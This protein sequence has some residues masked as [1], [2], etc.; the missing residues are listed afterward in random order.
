M[1]HLYLD[2]GKLFTGDYTCNQCPTRKKKLK[3]SIINCY[4]DDMDDFVPVEEDYELVGPRPFTTKCK[5]HYM[6]HMAEHHDISY[7]DMR[8]LG[9]LNGYVGTGY[10]NI[11]NRKCKICRSDF[12]NIRSYQSHRHTVGASEV[13]IS[14][15]KGESP[16]KSLHFTAE[17]IQSYIKKIKSQK[18]KKADYK[19]V[20]RIENR[21][22]T[23]ILTVEQQKAE[24][25]CQIEVKAAKDNTK[26]K[27]DKCPG[28]HTKKNYKQHC[29]TKRHQKAIEL[30]VNNLEN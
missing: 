27:C 24:K 15:K 30:I 10:S 11:L 9:G 16:L 22:P 20:T 1:E 14:Q 18:E 19:R 23:V 28:Y 6:A 21:K 25:A 4:K 29:R 7:T 3:Q 5:E 2:S 17:E 8:S 12:P 13:R 26:I